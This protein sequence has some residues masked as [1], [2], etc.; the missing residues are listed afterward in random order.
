MGVPQRF[1]EAPFSS[2]A[3]QKKIEEIFE[4]SK[5]FKQKSRVLSE[6]SIKSWAFQAY[7][8]F[9]NNFLNGRF[10]ELARVFR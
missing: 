6:K 2:Y 1:F 3:T 8:R 7:D 9:L 5:F 4:K 10:Y